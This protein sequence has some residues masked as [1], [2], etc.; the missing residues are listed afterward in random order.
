[1]AE[2]R[3]ERT[4]PSS[5]ISI[6]SLAVFLFYC[7]SS[8]TCAQA[9][10]RGGDEASTSFTSSSSNMRRHFAH[11]IRPLSFE[12]KRFLSS[13]SS[14]LTSQH[15]HFS[16]HAV[17]DFDN[18]TINDDIS[19][20]RKEVV[21]THKEQQQYKN[22]QHQHISTTI[23]T[24]GA[25][26]SSNNRRRILSSCVTVTSLLLLSSTNGIAATTAASS[27]TK[28]GNN[29]D[30]SNLASGSSSNANTNNSDGGVYDNNS[31]GVK[32][33]PVPSKKLGGLSNKIRSVSRIM[34]SV[35]YI[36]IILILCISFL[37]FISSNV[38]LSLSLIT[39]RMNYN[40]I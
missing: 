9:F 13:S 25:Y 17:G 31:R 21:M 15:D 5:V 34:V 39:L 11:T 38:S 22:I 6:V 16:T 29:A 12:R 18:N 7:C 4:R 30:I 36:T 35:V 14:S 33:M 32:G 3:V 2:V 10:A 27:I 26:S 1:M 23:P 28:N 20:T 19:D 8:A 40:V 37:L 24:K